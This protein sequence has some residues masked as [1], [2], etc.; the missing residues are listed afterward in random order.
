[1]RFIYR[2]QEMKMKIKQISPFSSC[3][4]HSK[5]YRTNIH[6]WTIYFHNLGKLLH[7]FVI[8]VYDDIYFPI[9]EYSSYFWIIIIILRFLIHINIFSIAPPLYEYGC[10]KSTR[11]Q[12]VWYDINM[13]LI[14]LQ[15]FEL[16]AVIYYVIKVSG[17]GWSKQALL[18]LG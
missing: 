12:I 8:H 15:T 9:S 10:N 1:M 14:M 6:G 2:F 13:I 4:L 5:R 17:K 16:G 18:L 3:P 7:S 11:S